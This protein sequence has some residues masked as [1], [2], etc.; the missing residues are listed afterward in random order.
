MSFIDIHHFLASSTQAFIPGIAQAAKFYLTKIASTKFS[1]EVDKFI[2]TPFNFSSYGIPHDR[3]VV[4]EAGVLLKDPPVLENVFV[5]IKQQQAKKTP[6]WNA[7]SVGS[8]SISICSM[9]K[10]TW[11]LGL[12]KRV[13]PTQDQ[14]IWISVYEFQ[15]LVS[16]L[17]GIYQEMYDHILEHQDDYEED[18]FVALLKKQKAK[19]KNYADNVSIGES[20]GTGKET[21]EDFIDEEEEEE[22]EEGKE[23]KRVFFSH[24]TFFVHFHFLCFSLWF[25]S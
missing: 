23:K 6:S 20:S 25:F 15:W 4:D 5:K 16:T 21:V 10:G 22:E 14:C 3:R 24:F 13:G 1:S 9:D 7:V 17:G 2:F 18:E 19:K 12:H 8:L 11:Y